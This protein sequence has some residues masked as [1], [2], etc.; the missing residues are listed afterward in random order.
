M[1]SENKDALEYLVGL[2]ETKVIEVDGQKYSTKEL[3]RVRDPKPSELNTTTLTA[4]VDYLKSNFDAKSSKKLLVHV[5]SPSCVELCSELRGDKDRE[6]YLSCEALTPNNIVFDRFLDTEQFNIMLQSS[7]VENKDRGLLL[8]VTG[9]VKDSAVKEVGDD[10]VSQA[11]TIKT[12]VASV[13]E[14][15]VPNPVVLAPFRTFPEIEQPESK[16]IFRMQSGPRA[17]LFEADGGAW[18]NE[19]MIKIKAY[20][21]EQLKGLGNIQII[22]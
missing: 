16:F 18:R 10:G 21:E 5:K 20:L 1:Y 6:Y 2:G 4:L 14:V 17:A 13:N 9:C 11:A 8:K 19:A 7:F 15:K 12:G 22:A 3:Y